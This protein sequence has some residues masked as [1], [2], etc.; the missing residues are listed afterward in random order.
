MPTTNILLKPEHKIVINTDSRT[1]VEF[2]QFEGSVINKLS[3]T[4]VLPPNTVDYEIEST[5]VVR[6]FRFK[7]INGGANIDIVPTG[8]GD[9]SALD[10]QT[11]AEVPV[12]PSGNLTSTDAQSAFE[13]L[14][15]DIDSISVGSQDIAINQ[16]AHG[17]TVGTPIYLSGTSY[18]PARANTEASSELVGVVTSVLGPDDF[19]H[20]PM[21]GR[22]TGLSA[23]TPGAVYWLSDGVAGQITTTMPT[24]T[25]TIR[26]PVLIAD[27]TSSGYLK[28]HPGI[29][30]D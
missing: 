21:Y 26:K 29:I 25:N 20:R 16:V 28:D 10:N 22:I 15:S 2:Y 24:A 27:T 14:Q 7:H 17:L 1:T 13:E 11:A 18:L 12:T 8:I 6:S 5:A 3:D 19:E 4:V 9:S 30:N 23:L